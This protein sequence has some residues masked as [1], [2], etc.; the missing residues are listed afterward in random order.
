MQR[1]DDPKPE[2][3]TMEINRKWTANYIRKM[4]VPDFE[5]FSTVVIKRLLPTFHTFGVEAL[6]HGEEWFRDKAAG[7]D[8]LIDDHYE[9]YLADKAMDETLAFADMLV[10][11]YFAS[12][13]LY[14]VGLFHL[15]EQHAADLPLQILE[16]HAYSK[17]VKLKEVVDWLKTDLSI[18]VEAF[19]TWPVIKELRLVANTIKHAE[20]GSATALR[21][22]RPDLFIYPAEREKEVAQPRL[23]GPV[24]GNPCLEKIFISPPMIFPV[25][26]K[27]SLL[28]GPNSR[29]QWRTIEDNPC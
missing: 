15:F 26:L 19:S 27:E 1:I 18:D 29:I 10:A 9:A 23:P 12:V 25:T 5:T 2:H 17:E 7:V 8:P 21:S 3:E 13:G 14:S 24:Y 11:M 6:K 20:G 16:A 4:I 28:S 22:C